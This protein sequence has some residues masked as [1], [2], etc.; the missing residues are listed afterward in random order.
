VD[1]S[2]VAVSAAKAQF[3]SPNLDFR[4]IPPSEDEPLPFP[5]GSFDVVLSFQVIEHV[6]DPVR[7]LSEAKRVLTD[8][9]TMLIATPDRTTRLHKGQRPWNRFHLREYTSSEFE[10]VVRTVFET[11][12]LYGTGGPTE[13]FDQELRRTARLRLATL[14][15][16][17]PG[18]PEGWRQFGLGAMTR[19]RAALARTGHTQRRTAS[20][21]DPDTGGA[22]SSPGSSSS[23]PGD[24][25]IRIDRQVSPSVCIVAVAR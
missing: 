6:E 14:P 19:A 17:F 8:G 4:V 11:V 2:P 24:S 18:C 22:G 3:S 12:D 25:G 10:E 20:A 9:G 1:V 23:N 5:E 13:T 7:Y 21:V 16:T 15:F